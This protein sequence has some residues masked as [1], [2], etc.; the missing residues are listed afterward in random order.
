M[1]N[2]SVV[3]SSFFFH[4]K[5]IETSAYCSQSCTA[6]LVSLVTQFVTLSWK[7]PTRPDCESWMKLGGR[8]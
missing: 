4:N 7:T 2:L 1:R 6:S 8:K 5:S 3:Q